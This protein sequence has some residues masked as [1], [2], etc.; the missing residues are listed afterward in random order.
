MSKI[1][2]TTTQTTTDAIIVDDD[3]WDALVANGDEI[4]S[5]RGMCG[6]HTGQGIVQVPSGVD[7]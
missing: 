5:H 6:K 3:E 4:G 2:D 7:L 1:T